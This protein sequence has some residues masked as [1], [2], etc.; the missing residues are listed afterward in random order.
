MGRL[1]RVRAGF[2][3]EEGNSSESSCS[4]KDLGAPWKPLFTSLLTLEPPLSPVSFSLTR[5]VFP[6]LR[7][8]DGP[9]QETFDQRPQHNTK[10]LTNLVFCNIGICTVF[11]NSI[12]FQSKSIFVYQ[13]QSYFVQ[14]ERIA[15]WTF[16]FC[17]RLAPNLYDWIKGSFHQNLLML[18]FFLVCFRFLLSADGTIESWMV[19]EKEDLSLRF[20]II[21]LASHHNY[22]F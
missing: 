8:E 3:A 1:T 6:S 13:R 15:H 4:E 5:V 20:K 10:L 19:L 7:L 2:S 21:F 17:S 12:C 9:A 22:I 11:C 16:A 18:T 14:Q